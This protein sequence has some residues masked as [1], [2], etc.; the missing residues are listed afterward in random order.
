V[1]LCR[2][3]GRP[4]ARDRRGH[5]PSIIHRATTPMVRRWDAGG[6]PEGRSRRGPTVLGARLSQRS[7]SFHRGTL[8]LA[9]RHSLAQGDMNSR[10]RHRFRSRTQAREKHRSPGRAGHGIVL[11]EIAPAARPAPHNGAAGQPSRQNVPVHLS[12][13]RGRPP[14]T[15]QKAGVGRVP[16]F[17][18]RASRKGALPSI[19]GP[20]D[21]LGGTRSLRVT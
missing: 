21:S 2:Q 14:E 19:G 10:S 20:F 8:R 9:R 7:A 16:Q 1:H 5:N 3:R 6:R 12:R 17:L 15:D 11:R 18:E 4:P 13:Q